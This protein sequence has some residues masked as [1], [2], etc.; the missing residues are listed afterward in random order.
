MPTILVVDDEQV[1]AETIAYNLRREGY[2]VKVAFDGEE[3]LDLA[4]QETPDL[5]LLDIMLPRLHGLEVCRILRSETTTPI[6]MLS[7]KDAEVDKVVGLEVGADDYITKPFSMRELIAR[8][9]AALRRVQ[10]MRQEGG[11]DNDVPAD[12]RIVFGDLEIDPDKHLV[13]LRGKPV[14]LKPK[15]FDLLAFFARNRGRV[16]SRD[17][18]LQR[19][20][21]YEF[22]GDTRTVD[23][24]VRGLREKIEDDPSAPT[25]IETVRGVGYRFKP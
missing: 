9:R 2:V 19:V 16:F 23:V 14:A 13:L 4:R 24:H 7:A 21:G 20:W 12:D 10:M 3:A 25:R 6:I 17:V 18:L 5:V 11:T 8:V 22:A 1:L 15:E